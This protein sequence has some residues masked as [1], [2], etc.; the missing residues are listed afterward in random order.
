MS[1]GF[2]SCLAAWDTLPLLRCTAVIAPLTPVTHAAFRRRV[3]AIDE[4]DTPLPLALAHPALW[5]PT[6]AHTLLILHPLQT[7]ARI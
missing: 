6:L 3:P 7:M 4:A 5:I 1:C 2:F